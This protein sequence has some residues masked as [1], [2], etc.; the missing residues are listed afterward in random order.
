MTFE[1]SE[2]P[3]VR[4]YAACAA[5]RTVR[6][7]ADRA[8]SDLQWGSRTYAASLAADLE[9][10]KFSGVTANLLFLVSFFCVLGIRGYQE[11]GAS[12]RVYGRGGWEREFFLVPVASSP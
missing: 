5:D 2:P 10:F 9:N 11:F 12:P 7:A 4:C 6:C 3:A 1:F 8:V